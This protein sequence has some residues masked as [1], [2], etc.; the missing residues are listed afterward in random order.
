MNTEQKNATDY[1]DKTYG[2]FYRK[3]SRI[4]C[5]IVILLS[6]FVYC[7]TLSP[8]PFPGQ[9]ADM[10][11]L[12]SGLVPTIA[13]SHTIWGFFVSKVTAVAGSSFVSALNVFSML[14]CVCSVWLFYTILTHTIWNLI[15]REISL[16]KN[17]AV[18]TVLAGS[19]GALAL[20]F[21]VPFWITATR[22]QY[23]SFDLLFLLL[24]CRLLL[25]HIEKSNPW[26]FLLFML[27][28]GVLA[29]ESLGAVLLLPIFIV[30]VWTRWAMNGR[31]KVAHFFFGII[32]FGIGL[33]SAWLIASHF[34]ATQDISLRGYE[35]TWDVFRTIFEDQARALKNAFPKR[36]WL[37]IVIFTIAPTLAAAMAARTSLAAT[38]LSR[39]WDTMLMHVILS[40][41]S[42]LVL[43]NAFRISPWT[44]LRNDVIPVQL[45]AFTAATIG[46][47]VAY[48]YL[49]FVNRMVLSSVLEID[50]NRQFSAW[51]GIIS[52]SFILIMLPISACIN[53]FES[54]GHNGKF[55]NQCVSEII[56]S[57]NGKRWLVSDGLFDSHL[58]IE[59]KRKN[60]DIGLIELNNNDNKV[61]LRHLRNVIQ[62]NPEFENLDRIQLAN[63]A[64]LGVLPFL[65][66]WMD[67]DTNV[68]DR[69]GIFAAPD[70]IVAEKRIVV[71]CKYFF[72]AGRSLED[73]KD[74]PFLSPHR[75]FW[76]RSLEEFSV[77]RHRRDAAKN[78]RAAIRR[79]IGFVANNAGV[80][81]EDLGLDE[82][83]FQ[84]YSFVRQIDPENVSTILNIIE[85]LHRKEDEGFHITERSAIEDTIERVIRE[86]EGRRLPFWSLSRSFGYVRSPDL[87]MQLG[88]AWAASGQPGLALAGVQR[89]TQVAGTQEDRIRA[90]ELMADLL[91][92][93][94]DIE[95]SEEI[96]EEIIRADPSN[97]RAMVSLAHVQMRRGSID[98]AREWLD[99]AR[100]KG[101]DQSTL[102]FESATID[103]ASGRAADARVKLAE[104]TDIY[105]KNIQAWGMLAIASMQMN[106]FAE[107]ESRIIPKMIQAAGTTDHYLILV[108]RG[109]LLLS[110]NAGSDK[111]NLEDIRAA[112][113]AFERASVLRQG[114]TKLLE[115]ILR[116]DF[117][118]G[119]QESA[120]LHARQLLRTNR[121]NGI[122]NYMM[123]SIM[124]NRGRLAESE[125]YLRRSI[126]A[127]PTPEALN[128]LSELLR[129]NGDLKEAEERIR[130]AISIAPEYYI[131]WDTLGGI[132]M[133]MKDIPNAEEAFMKSLELF[134]DDPRVKMNYAKL[135]I[136]K[137]EIVRARA[138]ISEVNAN[139]S[140]LSDEN[141]RELVELLRIVNPKK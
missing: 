111:R 19:I 35:T 23:Q 14:C 70:L 85:I 66:D 72:V 25:L 65:Q 44:I 36:G 135:L 82:E 87:F 125:D 92:R 106:D 8:G 32:F 67:A 37:L 120:E 129:K 55:V 136:K 90:Q 61:Y 93:Q 74:A 114:V 95:G 33:A 137:G 97:S 30:L 94:N 11:S 104:I 4:A 57:L 62:T 20:A 113:D 2:I 40:V 18:A 116:L 83:A 29:V 133:D 68:I 138:L 123:G 7:L 119:D 132:L 49:L 124:I 73:L 77:S 6:L 126:S 128:D 91:L 17:A 52:G 27:L 5:P 38:S 42:V 71:P 10:M 58:L 130:A 79:Q 98:K 110:R 59:A 76:K 103:I 141:Q 26:S 127:M 15:D 78:Y 89:A 64:S 60:L 118:L 100:E 1:S 102:A 139:R 121:N 54:S 16:P 53:A 24:L 63:S 131:V 81:L 47:L 46:Y 31:A 109:Q 39:K 140:S 56:E 51:I 88:W 3:Y 13:P 50:R 9:S 80:L 75:D 41:A 122:A 112:R 134:K 12:F 96:Y 21:S 22:L 45:A 105:P 108:I 101:I 115:S 84:T 107:V 117:T 48:W 28:Y 86:L 43:A 34:A 99:K 69:I